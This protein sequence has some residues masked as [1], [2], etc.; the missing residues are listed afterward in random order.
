MILTVDF[1]V[2]L[3]SGCSHVVGGLDLILSGHAPGSA[4]DCQAVKA[5]GVL[6]GL[7]P[8]VLGDLTSSL[9]PGDGWRGCAV[10]LAFKDDL[11]AFIGL[12]VGQPEHWKY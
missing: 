1:H 12:L 7:D 11:F 8:G 6:V 3:A 4:V 9:E 5:I 10:N 2:A